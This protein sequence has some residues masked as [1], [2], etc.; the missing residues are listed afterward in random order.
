MKRALLLTVFLS[1]LIL[2]PRFHQ[3]DTY[4]IG[5][6]VILGNLSLTVLDAKNDRII[7]QR[8]ITANEFPGG[9]Y[10]SEGEGF[11]TMAALPGHEFFLVR[12]EL[13]NL[14]TDM[15]HL[16]GKEYKVLAAEDGEVFYPGVISRKTRN[17]SEDESM[18]HYYPP[19]ITIQTLLPGQKIDGWI[20][21][22]IPEDIEP[23]EFMWYSDLQS[24]TPSFVVKLQ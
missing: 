10:F 8:F 1:L 16:T 3:S 19:L 5:G 21:F 11:E 4:P 17:S 20:V 6:Q 9:V 24:R 15:L 18:Y 22:E 13:I 23:K 7:V 14:G 12:L 2:G